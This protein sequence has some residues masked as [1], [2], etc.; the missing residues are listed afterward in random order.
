M[1][2]SSPSLFLVGIS[3]LGMEAASPG[4]Y[5]AALG[6][7]AICGSIVIF[8]HPNPSLALF[9]ILITSSLSAFYLKKNYGQ[10]SRPAK[11][12]AKK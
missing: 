4:L 7:G 6:A 3:L 10:A 5:L 1:E 8:I 11:R 12:K 9:T 2:L